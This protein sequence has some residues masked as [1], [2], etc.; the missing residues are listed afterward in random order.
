MNSKT[1]YEWHGPG[2]WGAARISRPRREEDRGV[3]AVPGLDLL[4]ARLL[5]EQLN[6]I[7]D[8]ALRER[9]RRAAAESASI[10]WST[11]YPLLTLPEL[12]A[13]KE[14]EA[15]LQH[16][17]QLAIQRRSRPALSNAE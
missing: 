8:A 7:Q 16:E 3:S 11:A 17:R 13:E 14:R 5:D 12:F 15:R 9:L 4:V 1:R 6:E 2:R 10:A